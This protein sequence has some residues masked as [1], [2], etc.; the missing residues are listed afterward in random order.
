MQSQTAQPGWDII[1]QGEIS[2]VFW[3]LA[4][5]SPSTWAATT[6]S[7]VGVITVVAFATTANELVERDSWVAGEKWRSVRSQEAVVLRGREIY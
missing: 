6:A 5:S 1:Q 4:A 2:W 7:N 3:W